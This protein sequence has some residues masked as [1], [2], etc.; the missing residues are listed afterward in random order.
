MTFDPTSSLE[1][2]ADPEQIANFRTPTLAPDNAYGA[3]PLAAPQ[4]FDRRAGPGFKFLVEP[5]GTPGKFD[6]P[7]NAQGTALI[8]DPR[9]DENLIVSQLHLAFLRF[10]NAARDHAAAALGTGG[11]GA[12]FAEARRLVRRHCQRMVIHEFLALT[13][14]ERVVGDVLER[15]LRLG[16]VGAHRGR[17]AD[18]AHRGRPAVVP[19]PGPGVDA[20]APH[21]R[22]VGPGARVSD[23]RSADVRRG[24]LSAAG[25]PSAVTAAVLL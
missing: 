1:R 21:L 22:A 11:P 9:N 20:H 15:G 10:H 25:G 14:G 3:G 19:E 24:D 5:C 7:R 13:C 16:P 8:G 18:R 2:R 23:G 12:V 6:L 4:L 17:G